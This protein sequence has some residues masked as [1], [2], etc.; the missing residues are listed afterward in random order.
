MFPNAMAQR[1]QGRYCER[2]TGAILE[3][4]S[5]REEPM[6]RKILIALLAA[7]V[8]AGW[9]HGAS[10]QPTKKL[11]VTI[12]VIGMNFLPLFVAADKGLFAKE[13]FDVEIIPTSGDG[14]DVDALIAGSVQFTISTPNRLLTSFEQGKPLL[15]IMNM[16]NRNAIDCV[17]NK[18]TAARVGVS[19]N[20]PL[21]QRL[22]ALKG[23]KVAGTRPGAFTYLVLVDYAKRASLVPQQDLQILG[24]GGGPGM[25]AA[26]ENGAV[27]VACNVSPSTDLMVK[28]GKAIMFTY[29]SLG[30]DPAYDDFLFELLYV[31]PDYAK[32]N[33]DLV[34]SFCR[35]LLAAI[36]DI[37]DT[38]AK[39]QLPLLR[40]RFS[41]V[42][43]DML[44]GVLETFKPMFRRDGKVTPVSLDKAIKFMLDTG[45][46]KSGAPWDQIA[47]YE[48]LPN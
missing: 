2:T 44:L 40:N 11:R 43:D 19:E 7:A 45:A 5:M 24:V 16:A 14:P 34:R 15:A 8:V 29:N 25:I 32:Q 18:D 23:L 31:R 12:P 39:D 9:A 47:T 1:G 20:T 33:P 28:R 26:I 36:A 4:R 37:R 13:G 41:G 46:I 6:S 30:K 38:P 21:E 10:A 48:F 17:I 22:K 42:E 35:A 27:D 3:I